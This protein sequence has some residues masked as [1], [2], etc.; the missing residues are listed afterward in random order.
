MAMKF[1]GLFF[2]L[3][4]LLFAGWQFN[5]PDPVWWVSLYGVVAYVSFRFYKG[6]Y[7][8]EL[9]LV[10]ILLYLAGSINTFLQMTGFEGFFTEGEGLAM[11]TPNQ[12]LAREASGLG[13][14]AAV[15]LFYVLVAKRQAQ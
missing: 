1:I 14:C 8:P 13:I 6:Q 9:L 4:F 2:T 7:N 12:E 11:K 10:L 15:L 5:D 3:V